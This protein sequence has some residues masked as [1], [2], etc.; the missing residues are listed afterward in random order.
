MVS[1]RSCVS[2]CEELLC[3]KSE[4]ELAAAVPYHLVCW[5]ILG[6]TS[7]RSKGGL[8]ESRGDE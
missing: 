8:T 2:G 7:D 5:V 6:S 4:W 1:Q 3:T